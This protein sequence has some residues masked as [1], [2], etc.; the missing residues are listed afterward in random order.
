MTPSSPSGRPPPVNRNTS[1]YAL[2]RREVL[3]ATAP[4]P[5]AARA[6]SGGSLSNM[7]TPFSSKPLPKSPGT[8]RRKQQP[9]QQAQNQFGSSAS[10]LQPVPAGRPISGEQA[11]QPLQRPLHEQQVPLQSH[12]GSQQYGEQAQP[13]PQQPSLV[14]SASKPLPKPTR[15]LSASLPGASEHGISPGSG[16]YNSMPAAAPRYVLPQ[17]FTP[18]P[19][20]AELQRPPSMPQQSVEDGD[21]GSFLQDPTT[22]GGQAPE[23]SPGKNKHPTVEMKSLEQLTDPDDPYRVFKDMEKIGSGSVAEVFLATDTRT[24]KKVAVKTMLLTKQN[25]KAITAEVNILRS[26][27]HPNI[28]KYFGCFIS[29]TNKLWVAMEFMAGGCL[30]DVLDE[31]DT[32][33]FEEKHIAC[34]CRDALDAL[35]QIHSLRQIHRDIKSDNVLISETGEVKLADFGFAAQLTQDRAKRNTMV[36]TPYWMA[37]EL[38]RGEQYDE[39]VDI[40]SLGIMVMEMAEGDP[41]YIDLPTLRALFFIN[42]KGAPPLKEP[43]KWTREFHTFLDACLQRDARCR[44][45]AEQLLQHPFLHSACSHSEL[46]QLVQRAKQASALAPPL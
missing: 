19:P 4:Q 10:P 9:Q 26:C 15:Q 2:K 37:P 36:G 6:S 44:P 11:M 21:R 12:Y 5:L 22:F 34:V 1:E 3:G 13:P 18:A 25:T 43:H 14:F 46:F 23:V 32:V 39:K 45:T 31:F 16:S 41:P 28:V 8:L 29:D 24:G 30:T 7:L 20:S 40:W 17:H 33:Q 35:A 42:T 38:V 27:S